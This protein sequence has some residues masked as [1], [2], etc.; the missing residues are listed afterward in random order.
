MDFGPKTYLLHSMLSTIFYQFA[1][2]HEAPVLDPILVLLV[3]FC[4]A[5]V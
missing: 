5:Q 4:S 2:R 1:P 3:P